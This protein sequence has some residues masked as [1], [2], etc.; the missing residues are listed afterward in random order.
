MKNK[1]AVKSTP[2]S[3]GGSGGT[4]TV[5][6]GKK[7]G[8]HSEK[9]HAKWDK[10]R[11]EAEARQFKYDKLTVDQKLALAKSRRG[12]VKRKLLACWRQSPRAR[13]RNLA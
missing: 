1:Y 6:K 9:L 4:E 12:E 13:K 5:S 10:K 3:G 7:N 11:A 2:F 8:Y